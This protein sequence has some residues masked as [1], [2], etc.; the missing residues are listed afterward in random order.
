M[1]LPWSTFKQI[2][3]DRKL[4][5]NYIDVHQMYWLKSFDGPFEVSCE[6]KKSGNEDQVDFEENYKDSSNASIKT[7]VF[8]QFEK[9]D[10]TLRTFSAHTVTDANG[11]AR[12][13]IQVPA[14]GRYV[15]YGDCEFETREFLDAVTKLEV[16]D[17]DRLVAWQIALSMNPDATEPVPDEV[18]QA[19][20]YP[21]Y[22][23]LDH[24]D[25]RSFLETPTENSAGNIIGGMAMT[26][27][28]GV[29]E[30][31]PVA[32]YAYIPAGLYLVLEATKETVV[33]D[34][35]CKIS[36]DW[37]EPTGT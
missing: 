34:K 13:A 2:I 20:G 12:F 10:K 26:F 22:P 25:E 7:E 27:K 3:A 6:I 15:A 23:I 30:A 36:I 32:G 9:N 16:S 4:D 33:A 8:T 14:K 37:A 19:N 29:T 28:Y 21:L 31:Q 5:V 35:R 11:V 17:L 24:Y 1:R 18:V